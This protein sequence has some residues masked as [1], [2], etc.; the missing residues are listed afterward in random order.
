M[1]HRSGL[2]A[3]ALQVE[4]GQHIE[5]EDLKSKLSSESMVVFLTLVHN[6]TSCG[7]MNPLADIMDVLVSSLMSYQ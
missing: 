7:M 4:W 6:E 3:D 1:A 2:E 5:T